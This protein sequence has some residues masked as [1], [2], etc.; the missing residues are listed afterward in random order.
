MKK[1]YT[2]CAICFLFFLVNACSKDVLKSYDRR[3]IGT[4][5]LYD[6][7]KY[8]FGRSNN[9]PLVENGIFTF[10]DGGQLSYTTGGNLYKGSWDVRKDY[11]NNSE[12]TN[13][14]SLHI[15]VIDFV[16]QK[17]LTEYFN[18]M[19]FT[20]TNRF[21]TVVNENTRSYVF[22]FLRE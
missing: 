15:T 3:V 8:G 18:R 7:D 10:S 6:I 17:V 13:V 9:I 5:K 16:N 1:V 14:K 4:W 21:N 2:L 11:L 22:R 12:D 20:N 19:T